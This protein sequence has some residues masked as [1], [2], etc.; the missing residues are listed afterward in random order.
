MFFLPVDAGGPYFHLDNGAEKK[1]PLSSLKE[2][3][4]ESG[5]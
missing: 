2:T 1:M 5:Y 4:P 3:V